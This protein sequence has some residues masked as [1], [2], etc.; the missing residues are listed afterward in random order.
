[1]YL[2][3]LVDQRSAAAALTAL[4][5]HVR[6]RRNR[7]DVLVMD[8]VPD[9]S[10]WLEQWLAAL[11]AQG[12]QYT[13]G[14]SDQ[15][16]RVSLAPTWEETEA[17]LP[18]A[19]RGKMRRRMRHLTE[20]HGAQ[21][22]IAGGPET[23]DDDLAELMALH[24]HRWT[25]AG[26]T[27]VF[28]EERFVNLVQDAAR[29]MAAHHQLTLA[30]LR[31]DGRRVA[32]ICGFRHRDEFHFYHGGLGDAGEAARYS[33]GIA[34]HLMAMKA[35]I[36]DGVRTYD[37]L[38]GTEPYKA[39]LGGVPN[40]TRRVTVAGRPRGLG[41]RTYQIYQAQRRALARI[42]HERRLVDEVRGD[43][44][45]KARDL[46]RHLT[47]RLRANVRDVTGRLRRSR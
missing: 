41:R 28:S 9:H 43:P 45:N 14:L 21:L 4:A 33:P 5:E 22:E 13:R 1:D 25:T 3:L 31:V 39:D 16:P 12:M 46:R 19:T 15:C 44:D 11:T 8:D 6:R 27:G 29:G 20:R 26:Q 24:Q 23:L 37:L 34:L 35:L 40:P 32:G 17:N 18:P 36:E 10:P 42:E 2:D 7:F 38:R 30:F 47:R